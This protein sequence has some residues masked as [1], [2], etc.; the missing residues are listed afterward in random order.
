MVQLHERYRDQG[1]EIL[2]FPCNQFMGQEPANEATIKA[3][4]RDKYNAQFPLFAKIEVNGPNTHEVYRFLRATNPAWVG[5]KDA[6]KR[7]PWNFAKFIVDEQGKVV[8]FHEPNVGPLSLENEVKAM[9][10]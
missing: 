7:I 10:S 3:F 9:C 8:S 6:G 5:T 2:A 1:F 4:A